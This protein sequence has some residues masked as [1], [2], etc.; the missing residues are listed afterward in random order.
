MGVY[1]GFRSVN[2]LWWYSSTTELWALQVKMS[3]LTFLLFKSWAEGGRKMLVM[4]KRCSTW[5]ACFASFSFTCCLLC[6]HVIW[7]G[8]NT[9][10]CDV[11]V[12]IYVCC[13]EISFLSLAGI[14]IGSPVPV[15]DGWGCGEVPLTINLSIGCRSEGWTVPFKTGNLSYSPFCF[16]SGFPPCCPGFTKMAVWLHEWWESVWSVIIVLSGSRFL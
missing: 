15:L 10:V 4:Q 8:I 14:R 6:R 2:T 3:V 9:Y 5:P 13:S 12:C 11:Y 1:W 7:R 16:F